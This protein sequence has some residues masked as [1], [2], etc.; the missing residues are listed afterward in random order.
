MYLLE[1]AKIPRNQNDMEDVLKKV[2]QM[3]EVWFFL[4]RILKPASQLHSHPKVKVAVNALNSLR[5]SVGVQN[6]RVGF[7]LQLKEAEVSVLAKLCCL[8]DASEGRPSEQPSESKWKNKLWTDWTKARNFQEAFLKMERSMQFLQRAVKGVAKITDIPELIQEI[9]KRKNF[10]TKSLNEVLNDS[11][12]G[13]RLLPLIDS[14]EALDRLH[15]SAFFFNIAHALLKAESGGM[16]ADAGSCSA[17]DVMQLLST[18]A[19]ERM[20]RACNP[21]FDRNSDPAIEDV[22]I[23]LN[24]ITN[25]ADLQMELQFISKYFQRPAVPVAKVK[26]LC[27]YLK[28]PLVQEKVKQLIPTLE[29]F[30]YDSANCPMIKTSLE[31]F[32]KPLRMQQMT[33]KGLCESLQNE[34]MVTIDTKLDKDLTDIVSVLAESR[35]LLLFIEETAKEDMVVL[36]DVVEE[37]SDQF[38]SEATVSHLIDVHRFLKSIVKD[39]PADPMRFLHRLKDCYDGLQGKQGM[40]AKMDECSH[41]VHSLRA[42]YTNVAN[43]GE[44]TKEIISNALKRGCYQLGR[45]DDG[46]WEVLLTYKKQKNIA[47][48]GEGEG[49]QSGPKKGDPDTCYRLTDLQDL[50]SRALLIVNIDSK[51]HDEKAHND[52]HSKCSAADL[53]E[54]VKQVDQIMEILSVAAVLHSTGHPEYKAFWVKLVAAHEIE[55]KARTIAQNL[56]N[57]KDILE[58]MQKRYFFLNFFHPDQL[59][60]LNDFFSRMPTSF[61]KEASKK[62][63]VYDLLR[64][65]EP[66]LPIN[67]LDKLASLYQNS[68]K[69]KTLEGNLCAIGKALDEFFRPFT[70]PGICKVPKQ[71]LQGAVE[72]GELF[73]AVLEQGSTQTVHVVM[74]IFELTTGAPPEPSQ[75][76]FCHPDT[77]WE[78]IQRL[79]RRSFEA[80][81][82]PRG[83]TLHCLA[84]VESLPND[85][86]FYLVAAIKDFQSISNDPYL[87]SL[88]CRGGPHHHIADQFASG[89]HN[90][91][92]MTDVKLRTKFK[93]SLPQVS[94]VTSEL[95]GMGKTETI[96][97]EA[98][99]GERAVV[100]F[101]I[102]GP[103]S[104][105]NLVHRLASLQIRVCDCIHLDIG[106]VDDPLAL[107]TFLFE[108]IVMGMV[109]S[110]TLIYHLPTKHVYIEIAN[111]LNDWLQD[112][113]PVTKCFNP[114]HV[115]IEGYRHYVVSQEPSSSIQVVCN[116]LHAYESGVLEGKELTFSGPNKVKALPC[117]RCKTLLRKYF[118]A[119]DISYNIVENF[120]GV[121]AD[122]LLKFSASPFL[123][124]NNLK[125]MVGQ[126]HD[127]R[128][129]LFEALLQVSREFAVRSVV[130]CKSIQSEAMSDK[131]ATDVLK[132]AQF[133]SVQTANKMVD[134]VEGM[135]QWADNNHLLLLFQRAS[136]ISV[137]YR[138]LSLVPQSVRELYKIQERKELED[139]ATFSQGKLQKKLDLLARKIETGSHADPSLKYALTPDNILKMV[140]ILLRIR[141]NIPVIIMGETGCG[142]TSLVRYLAKTCDVPFHVFNFH[143]GVTE[144]QIINF[145]EEMRD[146]ALTLQRKKQP[147]WIFLDEINTCDYLGTINEVMCHRTIRGET[148]PS[149]LVFIA[150][151][152]PYRLRPVEKVLTSGLSDKTSTD[153]YSKLVYRVHPLPET[154]IDYVWD[155]GSV[156]PEDETRYIARMVEGVF[157]DKHRGLLVELLFSSQRYIRDFESTPFCVS[158][159]DVYRCIVLMNWF[160]RILE[161]KE[162]IAAS[163]IPTHIQGLYEQAC[164]VSLEVRSVVLA[165]AHCYQS[166]LQTAVVRNEFCSQMSNIIG[167]SVQGFQTKSFHAIVRVE[168]EDY[169]ARMELPEGTAKN[170][171]LR[172][173]VFVMLVCILNHI[174]V[175]VVGKPGCSKSLSMQVIR[176][177]LRGKDSKDPFLKQLPQLYVVSYQGSESSTSEGILKVFEKARRYKVQGSSDV[178]PVVLLDEIGLAEVSAF[179]PLK[180]LH[181]LLEPGNG[182]LPDVAVVGIS[183]WCLDPAKMNRAIHL[184]RPEPD[185]EDLFQTGQSI[186][187]AQLERRTPLVYTS[188]E[189][190]HTPTSY[191]DDYQLHC[192]ANAYQEY[193]KAQRH[194][195]F[196]GL[197]DYYSL[198]KSLSS[199]TSGNDIIEG[200]E[201]RRIQRA[202]QRNFG[203]LPFES[204]KIQQL[205]QKQF[206]SERISEDIELFPVTDL[207]CDNL[208]DKFAR[209]MMIITNG[210]SAI[211]IL[212]QTLRGLE[213]EE[214][215]IFGSHFEEDQSEEYNYN[216]LSRIILCMER[217]CVLILRDLESIYGSLYDMLNQNYTVVGQKKNCRVA[218]GP[219]SNPMCQVD[220]E[221]RCIVLIDEQRVDYTDPPFL[222]RFEKQLLRFSDVLNEDQKEVISDL[223][224]WTKAISTFPEFESHFNETD[225]FMGFNKDTLPSL[226]LHISKDKTIKKHDLAEICKQELMWTS[227]PDGVLRSLKSIL[228]RTA[229]DEVQQ[230][231]NN[232]F[233]KPVHSGLKEY[234]RQFLGDFQTTP[235]D[236]N[237]GMKLLV[238]THSNIHTNV[239]QCLTGLGNCQA[240][241]LSAFKSEKQLAKQLQSFWTSNANILVLQCK[242]ELDAP[243]MLVAKHLI[244]EQRNTYISSKVGNAVPP[245]K[246]VCIIVHVQRSSKIRKVES[247]QWQFSFLSGW[248][249]VTIDTL[250][251]PVISILALLEKKVTDLLDTESFSFKRIASDQLLWCFTRIK[252]SSIK[253][254]TLDS[255]LHKVKWLKSSPVM[256]ECFKRIV[257][258]LLKKKENE[259]FHDPLQNLS[260]LVTVASNRLALVNSSTLVGAIEQ[261]FNHLIQEPLAKIVYFLEKESA[262]PKE[263]FLSEPTSDDK[264]HIWTELLLDESIF[265]IEDIPESQGGESYLVSGHRHKLEFP[266][267]SVFASKVDKIKSLFL[268]DLRRLQL[269]DANLDEN[270]ELE[271]DVFEAQLQRFVPEIQRMIHQLFEVEHL[272]SIPQ[273]YVDDLLDLKTACF[274]GFLSRNDRIHLLKSVVAEHIRVPAGGNFALLVTQL[275][276]AF[277]MKESLFLS[278]V[279]LSI[280]CRDIVPVEVKTLTLQFVTSFDDLMFNYQYSLEVE[281]KPRSALK[282]VQFI[283]EGLEGDIRE[284][285]EMEIQNEDKGGKEQDSNEA[286]GDG[287]ENDIP[288]TF[289]ELLVETF[290]LALFPTG[291]VVRTFQDPGHWQR[292]VSL[293]L[294]TVSRMQLSVPAFHFLRVCHD[295]VSLVFLQMPLEPYSLYMMG[296]IGH[297]YASE[298]YLDSLECFGRID[299][300]IDALKDKAENLN[301]LKEFRAL[302]YARCIDSNPD[303]PTRGIILSK[304]SCSKDK[305][306]IKLAGPVVHRILYVE[307]HFRPGIFEE[308]LHDLSFMEN[309]PGLQDMC[310]AFSSLPEEIELDCP[311]AVMCCDFVLDVGF[312]AFNLSTTCGSSDK[313]IENLRRAA[314]IITKPSKEDETNAFSLVCAVAYLRSFL[315]SFARLTA[316]KPSILASES[317]FSMLV[318][319]VNPV[320]SSSENQLASIRTSHT[321][322]YFLR[323]LRKHLPLYTTKQIVLGN[324]NLPALKALN[325]HPEDQTLIGKLSFDPFAWLT[326]KS[327]AKVALARL[328][329]EKNQEPLR[330]VLTSLQQSADK[331]IEL[332]AVLTKWFYLVRSVRNLGDSEEKA[333]GFIND[334][335]GD[336]PLPYVS[337]LQRII[338]KEDFQVPELCISS[339][340]TPANVHRAALILHLCIVLASNYTGTKSEY[341]AFL[342]YLVNPRRSKDTF[343]LASANNLQY[344]F[345]TY[346]NSS[347]FPTNTS[348]VSCSCGTLLSLD[349]PGDSVTCPEC[350]TSFSLQVQHKEDEEL[351]KACS[352]V[353]GYIL[354]PPL[355]EMFYCVRS[356]CPSHFRIIH[357]LVHGALYGGL[358]L[359]M[360]HSESFSESVVSK[361]EVNS[362]ADVC[363]HHIVSDLSA[364]C[365]LLNCNEE[366]VILLLHHVLEV[367]RPIL[368]SAGLCIS[369]DMRLSLEKRI[370]DAIGPLVREFCVK[371][372]TTIPYFG[373]SLSVTERQIEECDNPQFAGTNERNFHIPRLFRS[374]SSK[375][376]NSLR[377]YYMHIEREQKA[378]HPLLG[379]FFDFHDHLHLVA[380]L[381]NLLVWT[382]MLET[383]LNRRISRKEASRTSIGEII[384]GEHHSMKVTKEEKESLSNAFEKFK[385][386][387]ETIRPT[388]KKT[389]ATDVPHMTEMSPISLCLVERKDQGK[390]LCTALDIL[391]EIQ[392]DFIQNVLSVAATGKCAALSFLERGDGMA[393]VQTVHLQDA[394]D[395]EIIHYQW[396][397]DILKHSQHNTEYGQGKE[398]LYDIGRIEKELAVSFLFGKSYLST[399]GGLHE[400]MFAKELFHACKGI[401]DELERIVPQQPLPQDVQAGLRSLK[402]RSLKGVQDLL[403]HMEIILCLLKKHQYGKPSEPLIE[404]TDRWLAES[405]PFPTTLLPE[406]PRAILL[407]H[408]VSLYEFLEDLLADSATE[409]I[410]DMYRE[411]LPNDTRDQ[412]SVVI[413]NNSTVGP[414][415]IPLESIATAIR[416]FIFRY[417]SAEET[418]P[419]PGLSLLEHMEERSLWPM[420]ITAERKALT[421]GQWSQAIKSVFPED[422]TLGHI[423]AVLGF[424]QSQLEVSSS[425]FFGSFLKDF[426]FNFQFRF[427]QTLNVKYG[428]FFLNVFQF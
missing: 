382:R 315:S 78:E 164:G 89:A 26:M 52:L 426:V 176:S 151:C 203:G 88:V 368:T 412:M 313:S 349:N 272:Q 33:L 237:R 198:V 114:I 115:K 378:P 210:D 64:F 193:Q 110:G 339:E 181:S 386:A 250:E 59:W 7:L 381:S 309:H 358:A 314:E 355:K 98:S 260:W 143:A 320:L 292:S 223:G 206:Q 17:D 419:E 147:V 122:Q 68:S 170:G 216:I 389:I 13:S 104:R 263:M 185:V 144:T 229:M 179:N 172:E 282:A 301:N 346:K 375:S 417:M 109:S 149:N 424:Y 120:L 383:Q 253:Q 82:H 298:G 189:Y 427:P 107:D 53:N 409:G 218:L 184:S 96:C 340:S 343:I 400:F 178:L 415:H 204:N 331:K 81:R 92:G 249:Q 131:E 316:Q 86:Q 38:V 29:V 35:E 103:L 283:E 392:N 41:N 166:R 248:E 284:E 278:A 344:S 74:S 171:A 222:N 125:A 20:Q 167:K 140:L 297:A 376:L 214:V 384:R 374:T 277:W 36:I 48:G 32:V 242:P 157:D 269:E 91:T 169:L 273:S 158:L 155:Y 335:I 205:F 328:I 241:K 99:K 75:V 247:P 307:N 213:K 58:T 3:K 233:A 190:H 325:W 139:Y 142:K 73:V 286:D 259:N 174:P 47:Q 63:V 354:L 136:T 183:N 294:S 379:L 323:E 299:E 395:K 111:T 217:N 361:S 45:N 165:L 37:H 10:L 6:I 15:H 159:R 215:T 238:M 365:C 268:D 177:N 293:L 186:R 385:T 34:T 39:K 240:E 234:L 87:L 173:N 225:M 117:E 390:F 14:A 243:H 195:N 413:V 192:L 348:F 322:L 303:T 341:Q 60:I 191:P 406:P 288:P 145:L 398:I 228:S 342:S 289:A 124:P 4:L 295:F 21:L 306:L 196:H 146:D 130:T 77:S 138:Q 366:E 94:V 83:T 119:G 262:W 264:L 257:V 221:F 55:E 72:P 199:S 319:E 270:G 116:Y 363:F 31:E 56:K 258:Q 324:K 421:N 129:R 364:L 24:G 197:R 67:A 8:A 388:V 302:F 312:P 200:K 51:P 22:H 235:E 224:D 207:I 97:S 266:F 351:G 112:S 85:M 49:G 61:G 27:N 23:L 70:A 50:R 291:N 371:R 285:P 334:E 108:L 9:N 360:S 154:M 428:E 168:Q 101:P 416:R 44:M 370:S 66:S 76:L 12:W 394:Q 255:V 391:R 310:N 118:S 399:T 230:L 254:P 25:A 106:E 71:C 219:F 79:L 28:F 126:S 84:N 372:K 220:D 357:L 11:Y 163:K 275:H 265:N 100:T 194:E 356:L 188:P 380:H 290:C 336:L 62:S 5:A 161:E 113:L 397:N 274:A 1:V 121:F 153:E 133:G 418:R 404:F 239:A 40:A 246:H 311:F 276:F 308:L 326:E 300:L 90:I 423:H 135:I 396:S 227:T 93:E 271:A 337:L 256:M 152:N 362:F 408:V 201:T 353:K 65:I 232:F 393:A 304:I 280:K 420:E 226:V 327:T 332:A 425:I 95:P 422:L 69:R 305:K 333:I 42:L 236:A 244:E 54:F 18:K 321:R 369:E 245:T 251:E 231:S 411:E 175:F 318:R 148:L 414:D 208:H 410:H 296:E 137:L 279:H 156:S 43:R 187:E 352:P 127:V 30:G 2:M 330:S 16:V 180:V 252:Y 150:A 287:N 160:H 19:I 401:L 141:A 403:E 132:Q 123:K 134:R 377:A 373:A 209:H 162:K 367:T 350:K 211:G 402:E 57:W 102:S 267:V 407:M 212:D 317:E 105:S 345:Q 347:S 182:Q 80:H 261:Y 338:G 405:R 281:A 387:W 46:S 202:L 128:T 359:G 329:Q